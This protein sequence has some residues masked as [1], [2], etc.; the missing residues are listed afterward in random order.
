[1]Q[2]SIQQVRA[3]FYAGGV[4]KTDDKQKVEADTEII[5]I[6]P[7]DP[8]QIF[9]PNYD[10]RALVEAVQAN[11]NGASVSAPPPPSSS[12]T[13]AASPPTPPPPPPADRARTV[14]IAEQPAPR[15]H[16]APAP[17]EAPPPAPPA[18]PPAETATAAPV[19][20]APAPS[21]PAEL[22]PAPAAPVTYA[23]PAT[24]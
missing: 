10:P 19:E 18:A 20:P 13:P 22:A 6:T 15:G 4:L 1:V 2:D 17:A 3:E 21:P 11:D 14:E 24:Y 12:S 23:A 8:N 5:R 7:V 9:V 16:P